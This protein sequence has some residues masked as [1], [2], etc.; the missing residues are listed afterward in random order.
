[1]SRRPVE[2]AREP[3][4]L[5][6]HLEAACEWALEQGGRYVLTVPEMLIA[7]GRLRD[8]SVVPRLPV[9]WDLRFPWSGVRVAARLAGVMPMLDDDFSSHR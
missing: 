6:L 2:V 3:W 4:Q 9:E 8:G 1:M 5:A 7:A